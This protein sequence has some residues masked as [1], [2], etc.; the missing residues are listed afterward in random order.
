MANRL[1]LNHKLHVFDMD[2]LM[3]TLPEVIGTLHVFDPMEIRNSVAVYIGMKQVKQDEGST[4]LTENACD[5]LYAVYSYL[6]NL[7][8]KDL[9]STLEKIWKVMSFSAIRMYRS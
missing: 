2:E 6:F 5:E 4:F 1:K 3:R 7:D 9:K 8:T